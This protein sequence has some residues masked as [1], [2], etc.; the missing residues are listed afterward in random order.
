MNAGGGALSLRAP[1]RYVINP[2]GYV[3]KSGGDESAAAA[4][5]GA[6]E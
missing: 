6:A 5:A 1:C 4:A 2:K 3:V